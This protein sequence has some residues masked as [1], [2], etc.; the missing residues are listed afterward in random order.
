MSS[1]PIDTIATW[2]YPDDG[3]AGHVPLA[4]YGDGNCFYTS[5]SVS[6][7]GNKDHHHNL[8]QLVM[9]EMMENAEFYANMYIDHAYKTLQIPRCFLPRLYSLKH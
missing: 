6:V 4:V 3:P 7:Y 2:L 8:H 9:A 1:F 5:A